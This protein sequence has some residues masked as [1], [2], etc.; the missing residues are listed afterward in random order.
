MGTLGAVLV[1]LLVP[2]LWGLGSAWVFDRLRN[3][4]CKGGEGQ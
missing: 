1:A 3:R 2:L 4:R